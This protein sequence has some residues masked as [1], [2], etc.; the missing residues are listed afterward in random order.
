MKVW[1]Q[2]LRCSRVGYSCGLCPGP[3]DGQILLLHPSVFLTVCLLIWWCFVFL[4]AVFFVRKL[5]YI[6]WVYFTQLIF[7]LAHFEKFCL[8]TQSYS[9]NLDVT[10]AGWILD[11]NSVYWSED[12]WE[13][14]NRWEKDLL[15][16]EKERRRAVRRGRRRRRERDGR[17]RDRARE[18][19]RAR[20]RQNNMATSFTLENYN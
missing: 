19:E 8:Q 15:P 7:T 3:D 4:H 10:Y 17:E 1:C 6:T 14:P 20:E 2:R 5:M 11:L 18:S 12:G 13:F 9:E 16:G